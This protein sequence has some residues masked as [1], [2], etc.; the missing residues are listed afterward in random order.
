MFKKFNFKPLLIP[1][2]LL[3]SA[4]GII[5]FNACKER[6]NPELNQPQSLAITVEDVKAALSKLEAGSKSSRKLNCD[7]KNAVTKKNSKNE[8]YVQVAFTDLDAP[9]RL[10]YDKK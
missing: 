3:G 6:I 9:E 8:E 7:W 5:S 1:V 10:V 4:I 2:L